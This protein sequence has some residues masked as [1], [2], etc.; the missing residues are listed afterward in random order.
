MLLVRNA[1]DELLERYPDQVPSPL[2]ATAQFVV[3]YVIGR[4]VGCGALALIS[5]TQAEVKRM[6]VLPDHRRTGVARRV[7]KALERRAATAG[8]ETVILETGVRQGEAL[9]L[10]EA[11]GYERTE[12]YGEYIGNPYSVCFVKKL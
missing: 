9:G 4:P 8:I 6:Y 3:A 11:A 2:D 7:L 5:D 12:P 10:Y 1:E